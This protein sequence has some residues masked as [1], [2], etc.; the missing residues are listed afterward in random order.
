M[1]YDK[2]LE[3][4]HISTIIKHLFDTEELDK[5]IKYLKENKEIICKNIESQKYIIE[6]LNDIL[7]ELKAIKYIEE[8]NKIKEY[9]N[10]NTN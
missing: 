6:S 7:S 9:N 8:N 2:D 4:I 10:A 3:F 5:I 1:T